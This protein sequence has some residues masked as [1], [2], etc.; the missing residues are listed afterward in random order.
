VVPQNPPFNRLGMLRPSRRLPTFMGFG[1]AQVWARTLRYP[2]N[3]NRLRFSGSKPRP[4]GCV[5]KVN[6]GWLP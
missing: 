5:G 4:R 1:N 6:A 3:T 2:T